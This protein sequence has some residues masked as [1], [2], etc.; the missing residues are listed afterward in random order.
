MLAL[1]TTALD[2]LSLLGLGVGAGFA[3]AP[4][5]LG[6]GI[7]A[8]SVVIGVGSALAARPR[9]RKASPQ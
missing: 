8:G 3:V 5:S 4:Y 7:A 6:G 9:K 2:V 1:V